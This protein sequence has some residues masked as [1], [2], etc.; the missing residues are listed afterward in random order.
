MIQYV[1]KANTYVQHMYCNLQ[2]LEFQ[3]S[4]WGSLYWVTEKKTYKHSSKTHGKVTLTCKK[5][6][7][8]NTV[9]TCIMTGEENVVLWMFF[10]KSS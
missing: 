3:E 4:G 8:N 6:L 2:I 5:K 10:M 9:S 1:C 7:V